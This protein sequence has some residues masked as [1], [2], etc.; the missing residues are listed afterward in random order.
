M[1]M[2]KATGEYQVELKGAIDHNNN[3]PVAGKNEDLFLQFVA[4]KKTAD[5]TVEKQGFNVKV[6]DD[7]PEA[8]LSQNVVIAN[9]T[10]TS[11]TASLNVAIGADGWKDTK[12]EGD[13]LAVKPFA[14]TTP[15]D[16]KNT[17]LTHSKQA[18]GGEVAE[19]KYVTGVA[20][21]GDAIYVTSGGDRLV[22]KTDADGLVSAV[23]ETTGE[24]VFTVKPNQGSYTVEM[25]GQVDAYEV[26]E[27]SKTTTTE[28]TTITT[29]TQTVTVEKIK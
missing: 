10:N 16:G 14:D 1:T 28:D 3:D 18:A 8:G 6:Q 2:D 21:N 29:G 17:W 11:A 13:T 27:E 4:E 7:A 22:Y 25:K 15:D 20:A 12:I 24:V 23:K 9:Q 19:V 26:K 5:G